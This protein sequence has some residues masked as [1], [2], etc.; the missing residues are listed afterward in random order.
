[1]NLSEEQN[2]AFN[3]FKKGQNLVITGPGGTGKSKL[4]KH[5]V[6]HSLLYKK[7]V[8]VTALTG[9]A[10][11]LLGTAAKTIH[12]WA[13]IKTCRGEK[14]E[15]IKQAVKNKKVRN[16]WNSIK[17]LIIDEASMMSMKMFNVLNKLAQAIRNSTDPF[18]GIQVVLVGDFYQLPPIE[19][20]NEPDTGMFCF[21]SSDYFKAF[22]LQN[23]VVLKKIFRQNDPVYIKILNEIRQG[24]LSEESKEIL[25]PYLKRSFNSTE[26]NGAI[27]T[28]LFP[29]RNR[30]DAMN[31]ALFEELE[32]A[33]KTYQAIHKTNNTIYIDTSKSIE[34]DR[35]RECQ[36]LTMRDVENEVQMLMMNTPCIENLELKIGAAVMCNANIALESGIC[37]GTQGTIMDF[38][39]QNPKVK[40]ANGI[41]MVM[42]PHHWQSEQ[43]P[44]ISI[45]QYPLQLAWALTIHKIQGTTL[46]MAQID[47]GKDI[48]AYGQTYVALSRIQSL[49]GLYLSS[50]MPDRVKADPRVK[51]FYKKLESIEDETVDDE[52]VDD[53][54][55]E[56]E[57]VE[58]TTKSIFEK[59][60]CDSTVKV[61][62]L[63]K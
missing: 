5:L 41:V 49:D 24:E 22:P 55:I 31:K 53:E 47:I 32:D 30:V 10:A 46:K 45:S 39:G 52:T 51:D 59:F 37:N 29:V 6:N 3:K 16:N 12:S 56:N 35:L 2:L 13:G 1:M 40:F 36:A 7:K 43:Y 38:V 21:E 48:F 44:T 28:K 4:I 17:V 60:A 33:P 63:N 15:I 20:P 27:L 58:D 42:E 26:H 61:I 54:I 23:H 14:T 50:F 62:K 9:C 25:K 57:I 34:S 11:I 8:Q 18:G 19:T